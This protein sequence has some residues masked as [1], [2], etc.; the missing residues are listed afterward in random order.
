MFGFSKDNVSKPDIIFFEGLAEDVNNGLIISNITIED[1]NTIVLYYSEASNED[2][3]NGHFN[4][5]I[6][7]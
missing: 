4:V 5:K 2:K 3:D 6:N 1:L 7:C